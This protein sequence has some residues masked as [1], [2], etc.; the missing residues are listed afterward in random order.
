MTIIDD[1]TPNLSLPL[2]NVANKQTDDIPRIR[3][4]FGTIDTVL[5]E[6]ADLV[7]GKVP[8]IQ[9]PSFV[10]DVVE[11]AAAVD[12]PEIGE[13]GKIYIAINTPPTV[14]TQQFRWSGSTYT[15]I[16]ASPGST[17][18]VPEGST[19]L[20]FTTA[21]A[22]SAQLLASVAAPGLM[23]P[24]SGMTADPDG[25]VHVIAA[26]GGTG[27]PAYGDVYPTISSNGQTLLTV[28]G[29][30]T[31]GLIDVLLN[32]VLLEFDDYTA[33]NGTTITLVAGVNTTDV[34]RV[35]RWAYTPANLAVAKPG[36]KM[37]GALDWATQVDVASAAS[38]PI[39][40]VASNL[41]RI[42][43]TT[44]IT[45]F[46]SIAAGAVR[47]VTFAGALVLTHNATSLILPGAASIT[48]SAGDTAEFESLGSG[49]WRCILYQRAS[50]A[51]IVSNALS[52]VKVSGTAQAAV[53][54]RE[55]FLEN[56]AATSVSAPATTV[57]GAEF[58]VTPANGLLTN[59][60][61]FGAATVRGPA[62]SLTGVV[63]LD[64]GARL[65]VKY[66][67]TI[68]KWVVIS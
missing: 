33:T 49:N 3:E 57:D 29:G 56:A 23:K 64:R 31:A 1:R 55:Y 59:T 24:G 19:N 12:F 51:A 35:R 34:V 25:T 15:E 10:D 63:T 13:S 46:G 16:T 38:T 43:G 61:D 50:G 60:V 2:P 32:G 22:R 47:K 40:P 52:V 54:G 8:A 48:T 17:D 62:G 58:S 5:D 37:T 4:A 36:D 21:R 26:G 65:H 45:S 11:Y 39:G 44:T 30:Y 67:A 28:S 42:T 7:S 41:V 53:V 9:L 6:K 66:S 14:A 18:A 20:Y 27:L 68:S